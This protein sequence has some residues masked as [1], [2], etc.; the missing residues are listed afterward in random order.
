M[1]GDVKDILLYDAPI[2]LGV[3]VRLTHYVDDNIFHDQ[4]NGH[5]VM[6]ILHLTNK[7]TMDWYSKKQNTTETAKC[8]SEFVYDH[9]CVKNIID[10]RKTLQCIGVNIHQK[11][12]MFGY[13][14]SVVEIVIH[15]YGKLNKHQ[16]EL[17]FHPLHEAIESK[18]FDL[19]H[20]SEGDNPDDIL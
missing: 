16:N 18:I 20:V 1:Y 17:S 10:L 2:S 13:K 11:R 7:T 6:G 12:Y 8:G 19:Y 14:K 3:Y 15:P 9:T 5:F 4:I